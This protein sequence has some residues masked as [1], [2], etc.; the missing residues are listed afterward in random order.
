MELLRGVAP[1]LEQLSIDE[2]FLDVTDLLASDRSLTGG[3][4]ALEIQ[5][6]VE[7]E[8]GLSC[9]LGVASNKMVAKIANDCGKAAST[10][11]HSPQAL[12]VVETG[13]EA[14]F[15]APLSVSAL[16]GVGPKLEARLRDLGIETIGTLAQWDERDLMR[17]FG[18]HG[19]DLAKHAKGIDKREV[20]TERE[21]KSISSE[22]TFV[23]DV[24]EWEGLHATLIEQAQSVAAQLQKQHL[25]A[26]TVKLKLRW[27][28]FTFSTR[29]TT[30]LFATDAAPTIEDAAT[31]L[32]KELWAS[33]APVRLL[34]VGV[35][36]LSMVRQL[37][38][39]DSVPEITEAEETLLLESEVGATLALGETEPYVPQMPQVVE[40]NDETLDKQ[41]RWRDT[42]AGLEVRFGRDVVHLGAR[43]QV[44]EI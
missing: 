37:G 9:S 27:S 40:P 2:A 39:F 18:K 41:R 38:L 42:V 28:D 36:G 23:Q 20:V 17:R 11:G 1:K 7:E 43:P 14:E 16:W 31:S 25:Q 44:S 5:R 12:C 15:L 21:S 30:L 32:L 6:R 35:S 13:L 22:T 24:V 8:L 10:T 19:V 26:T 29:Q 33:P 4:L 34:G 3:A